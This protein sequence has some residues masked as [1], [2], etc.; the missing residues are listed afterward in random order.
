MAMI[1]LFTTVPLAPAS[2]TI[3]DIPNMAP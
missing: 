2:K 1:P 3:P